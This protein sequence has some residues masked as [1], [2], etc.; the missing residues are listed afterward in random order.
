MRALC[1][2][3]CLPSQTVS[4]PRLITVE[5]IG[6]DFIMGDVAAAA[7]RDEYLRADAPRRFEHDN[8]CSSPVRRCAMKRFSRENG[9][10]ESR[11]PRPHDYN[12]THGFPAFR[13]GILVC[14]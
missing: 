10:C 12:V 7:A 6:M 13:A 8:P 5:V 3:E 11:R 14:L 2:G 4:D 9:C 1:R